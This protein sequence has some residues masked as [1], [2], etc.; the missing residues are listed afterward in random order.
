MSQENVEIVRGAFEAFNR[1]G[2]EAALAA[3]APDVE[4]HDLPDQPDAEVHH[5]QAGVLSAIEQFFGGF[6]DY[7]VNLDEIIDHGEQVVVCVRT[8][9]RGRASGARFEQRPAGGVWTVRNG[10]V[11]RVVWFE[12]RREAVEAAGLVE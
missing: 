6:E 8:I 7:D 1:D 5:G 11:V 2:P 9:G 12:T 3:F 10:L 4:W